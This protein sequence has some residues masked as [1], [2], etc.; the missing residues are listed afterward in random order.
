[1]TFHLFVSLKEVTACFP[2][3]L[4]VGCQVLNNSLSVQE[5]DRVRPLK[6]MWQFHI[7]VDQRW[8][9]QR[10]RIRGIV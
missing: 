8:I 5:L 2:G 10:S 6:K 3:V 9:Q 1:M 4:T 7:G